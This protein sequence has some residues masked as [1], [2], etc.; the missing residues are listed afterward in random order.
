MTGMQ[1]HYYFLCQR[2]LWL[3]VH[4]ID[5][6][7]NSDLVAHGRVISENTFRREKKEIQIET[8]EGSIA[9][10]FYDAKSRVI[11]E[12]KKSDKMEETH[13]WQ[14]K[15][16]ISV[17]EDSGIAGVTGIINY[18]KL[19]QTT[20]VELTD[21]DRSKLKEIKSDIKRIIDLPLPPE[22][23]RKTFCKNC[24]YY[25]LCFI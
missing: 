12:V 22:A 10:D 7:H 23:V 4:S 14:T 18:P 11:H 2:K 13:L 8:E 17:L 9:L 16:Y 24:S 6:E 15:F 19:K 3:F 5:M 25:D 1:I 21:T 20:K